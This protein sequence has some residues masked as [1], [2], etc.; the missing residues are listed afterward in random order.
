V[1]R[2]VPASAA[3][4][5]ELQRESSAEQLGR[6]I[7]EQVLQGAIPPGTPL[8]EAQLVA[9]AGVSRTTAR[10]A[11]R[12]LVF[13]GLVQHSPHRGAIVRQLSSADV[14]DIYRVRRVIESAAVDAARQSAPERQAALTT[15]LDELERAAEERD[16]TGLVEADL[17]FHRALVGLL[18]SERL[19]RMQRSL[20]LELRLAFSISA[21]VDREFEDPAPIV[22]DHR[23][24]VGHLRDGDLDRCR[25]RLLAHL[26][27]H[28]NGVIRA[29]EGLSG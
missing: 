12:L 20:E 11:L 18:M 4:R 19:D 7:R 9:S 24:I 3:A 22:E 29:L 5:L 16:W 27:K 17:A 1:S 6:A 25:S 10:E 28:E 14:R 21:F 23:L 8:R 2:G 26:D 13:Q 15:A